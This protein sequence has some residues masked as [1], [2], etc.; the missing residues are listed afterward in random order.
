MFINDHEKLKNLSPEIKELKYSINNKSRFKSLMINL[1]F[2]LIV[3][4]SDHLYG[5]KCIPKIL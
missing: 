4:I 5:K 1:F 2:G 3:L